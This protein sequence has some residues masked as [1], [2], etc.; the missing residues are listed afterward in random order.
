MSPSIYISYCPSAMWLWEAQDFLEIL[1]VWGEWACCYTQE[2]SRQLLC[3][4][5]SWMPGQWSCNLLF[6][7]NKYN[8][9]KPHGYSWAPKKC[10]LNA[11]KHASLNDSQS[12]GLT[13]GFWN[14][15]SELHQTISVIAAHLGT[16]SFADS[17]PSWDTWWSREECRR[18][19][20]PGWSYHTG[21]IGKSQLGSRERG[22]PGQRS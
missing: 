13:A 5:W 12:N 4:Q 19:R 9:K 22:W 10:L 18:S 14:R 16:L 6:L 1:G 7:H 3:S 15:V 21:G 20:H 2:W 8:M 11:H 17:C